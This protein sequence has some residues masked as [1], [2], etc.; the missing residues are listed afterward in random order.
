MH[1]PYALVADV[2]MLNFFRN[3]SLTAAIV[4]AVLVLLSSSSR[5]SGAA[6]SAPTARSWAW[7]LCSA[8]S[9]FA[10]T[11]DACID[12]GKCAQRLPVAPARR[13][14]SADPLRR[15][16]RLHGLRRR[17]LRAERSAIRPAALAQH[18]PP[19]A[20]WTRRIASPLVVAATAGLHLLRRYRL[21]QGHRPLANQPAP[22]RLRRPG[23]LRQPALPPRLLTSGCPEPV[24]SLPKDL[25]SETWESTNPIPPTG[26]MKSWMSSSDLQAAA[27]APTRKPPK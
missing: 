25:A 18:T 12:C 14:V 11:P 22:R 26:M 6:T 16:H 15:V 5:T 9:K 3:M 23:S 10:A 1:A 13:P 21:R 7:R 2:K 27:L 4:I 8:R 17:L 19:A 20:R 24:L